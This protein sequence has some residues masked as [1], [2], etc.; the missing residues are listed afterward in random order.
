MET[1]RNAFLAKPE[2]NITEC[3]QVI[4]LPGLVLCQSKNRRV[5]N[6]TFLRASVFVEGAPYEKV[7]LIPSQRSLRLFADSIVIVGHDLKGQDLLSF[8]D[9]AQE[10]CLRTNRSKFCLNSN[11]SSF[12]KE[13]VDPLV[14][15]RENKP[16]VVIGVVANSKDWKSTLAH[17]LFHAQYFLQA[18]YNRAVHAY[19]NDK[20]SPDGK[21]K[22]VSF[23]KGDYDSTNLDLMINE[24]QAYALES[25][26]SDNPSADTIESYYSSLHAS[27]VES[28]V[29][30][31]NVN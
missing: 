23:L 16:L 24:F 8:R 14:K 6:R 11:E 22:V 10:K 31:L 28:G 15:T 2:K 26:D 19:W 25:S 17:E 1:W 5:M 18:D 3:A 7:R 9:A 27:L 21:E 29:A 30:L 13:V 12:F 20:V 4:E